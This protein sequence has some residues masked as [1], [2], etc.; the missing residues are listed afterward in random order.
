MQRRVS[1][2]KLNTPQQGFT[3]VEL[4]IVVVVIA[5]LAA[6]TIVAYNGIQTRAKAAVISSSLKSIEKAL[7]STVMDQGL[8]TWWYDDDYRDEDDESTLAALIQGTQLNRYLK[9]VPLVIG[10][11]ASFWEWDND[12]DDP[13]DLGY[14]PTICPVPTGTASDGVNIKIQLTEPTALQIDKS[15]DDGNLQCGRF[16]VDANDE[17]TSGIGSVYLY[18]VSRTDTVQ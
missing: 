8:A 9:T 17:V 13:E 16:R 1:L 11:D 6:I 10:E 15:V 5:I 12:G 2:S 18:L 4:L 14:D 3:I 7:K